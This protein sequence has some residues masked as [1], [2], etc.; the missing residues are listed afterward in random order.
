VNLGL[1]GKNMI[2]GIWICGFEINLIRSLAL[3]YVCY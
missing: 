1:N 3:N 2:I